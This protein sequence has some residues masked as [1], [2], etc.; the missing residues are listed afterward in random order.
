M[1]DRVPGNEDGGSTKPP[2]PERKTADAEREMPNAERRTPLLKYRNRER[3]VAPGSGKRV[4][5]EDVVRSERLQYTPLTAELIQRI[6]GFPARRSPV[7]APARH[8]DRGRRL[9]VGEQRVER[10]RIARRRE[11]DELQPPAADVE[12]APVEAELGRDHDSPVVR[13]VL[14][15]PGT[16]DVARVGA[17]PEQIRQSARTEPWP[18]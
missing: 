12:G 16:C 15:D 14:R 11:V 9:D 13:H 3:R 8:E 2:D 10:F 7:G 6:G 4:V 17:I 5:D 18:W 1:L